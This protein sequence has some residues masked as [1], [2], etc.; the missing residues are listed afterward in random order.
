[1]EQFMKLPPAQKAAV[2]AGI[3]VVLALGMYFLLVDPEL[4]KTDLAKAKLK[5]LTTDVATLKETASA[6]ELA[7][8]R[9]LKDDLVEI[10]KEN[11]K[12][13]PSDADE[14]PDLIEKM[15][16]DADDSE[17]LIKRF[18][19]LAEESEDL[20][21][22]IPIKMTVEGTAKQFIKFLRIY[23]GNERRVINIR[24]LQIEKLQA[25]STLI[26]NKIMQSKPLEQQKKDA[27]PHT[28]EEVLTEQ[29]EIAEEARKET[30]L[31]ATFTAYAFVWTDKPPAT[32][33]PHKEKGKKRRT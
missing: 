20:Y 26:K 5:K 22:A 27:T 6:E 17:L 33:G 19:R 1:M 28:P 7:K 21:N 3:L 23:A 9:K 14:I 31:R 12:M 18:D 30:K 29:L 13:L 16:R 15:K 25:D 10:D 2:L 11:R 24:D 32:D 4:G 8:I